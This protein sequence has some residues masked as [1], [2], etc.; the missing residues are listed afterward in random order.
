MQVMCNRK[1]GFVLRHP[2]GGKIKINSGV[3]AVDG[4][5]LEDAMGACDPRWVEA[6]TEPKENGGPA[7]LVP[8][9]ADGSQRAV[10]NARE[11]IE[12]AKT[13]NSMAELE[14]LEEDEER[15]TV[16]AAIEKRAAELEAAG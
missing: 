3:N 7:D 14:A 5:R 8:L 12:L 10:I 9:G 1:G 11:K 15:T 4:K 2:D 6:I 16:L 13:A